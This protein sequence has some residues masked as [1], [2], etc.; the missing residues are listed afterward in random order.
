[1]TK[2]EI[3]LKLSIEAIKRMNKTDDPLLLSQNISSLY[4]ELYKNLALP[5]ASQSS[6]PEKLED[7]IVNDI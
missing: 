4:N 1:M 3:A 7:F 2:E 6:A 5:N